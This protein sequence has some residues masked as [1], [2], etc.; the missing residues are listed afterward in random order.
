MKAFGVREP[1]IEA[2]FEEMVNL[3]DAKLMPEIERISRQPLPV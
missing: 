3:L 2:A 1:N